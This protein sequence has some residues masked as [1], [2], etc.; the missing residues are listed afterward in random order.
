[1]TSSITADMNNCTY[2]EFPLCRDEV[3]GLAALRTKVL[4]SSRDPEE[5]AA[6]KASTKIQQHCAHCKQMP[7]VRHGYCMN[8]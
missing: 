4:A 3:G 8:Y 7:E 2:A 1:M 6:R 5:K